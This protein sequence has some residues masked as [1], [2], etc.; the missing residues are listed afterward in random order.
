MMSTTW[1]SALTLMRG[2]ISA[3]QGLIHLVLFFAWIATILDEASPIPTT[4]P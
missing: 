2:R 4:A 3:I 1:L